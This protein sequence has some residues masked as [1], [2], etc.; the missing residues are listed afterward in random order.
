MSSTYAMMAA[1]FVFRLF[2]SQRIQLQFHV[3]IIAIT[4]SFNPIV[5]EREREREGERESDRERERH[6]ES[7]SE[8]VRERERDGQNKRERQ[9]VCERRRHGE[10]ERVRE[11]GDPLPF[12]KSCFSIQCIYIIDDI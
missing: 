11:Q 6:G 4:K 2:L 8:R 1:I 5:R 3:C 7:A 10:R 12:P 9:S